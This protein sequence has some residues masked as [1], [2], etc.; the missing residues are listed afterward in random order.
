M[1][2]QPLRHFEGGWAKSKALRT[3]TKTPLPLSKTKKGEQAAGRRGQRGGMAINTP[4]GIP[5][6][7]QHYRIN[8][9]HQGVLNCCNRRTMLYTCTT[10]A[11]AHRIPSPLSSI[12]SRSL[13]WQHGPCKKNRR[14]WN[15]RLPTLQQCLK[16]HPSP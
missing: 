2:Y 8:S 9:Q 3:L 14:S 6:V 5:N 16:Q 4:D 13:P 1:N 7:V 12:A 15:C 11:S 10:S